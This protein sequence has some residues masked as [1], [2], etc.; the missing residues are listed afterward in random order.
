MLGWLPIKG[1]FVMRSTQAVKMSSDLVQRG[2]EIAKEN[3]V[4]HGKGVELAVLETANIYQPESE[5]TTSNQALQ[6]ATKTKGGGKNAPNAND[7]Q[8][9][10]L[11]SIDTT[12]MQKKVELSLEQR[13]GD[14]ERE[15]LINRQLSIINARQHARNL[16]NQVGQKSVTAEQ[17]LELFMSELAAI[18]VS[19]NVLETSQ[20]VLQETGYKTLE[21]EPAS[22]R[23]ALTAGGA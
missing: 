7:S 10:P 20:T 13:I 5:E 17:Q 6:R 15:S 14:L 9:M 11:V 8:S 3:G 1:G 23:K 16:L 18:G 19:Q 2:L 12:P 22:K 21:M 4:T